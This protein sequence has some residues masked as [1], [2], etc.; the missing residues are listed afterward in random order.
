MIQGFQKRQRQYRNTKT[1]HHGYVTTERERE[2][3]NLTKYLRLK[4]NEHSGPCHK[5]LCN[6]CDLKNTEATSQ[7]RAR[8]RLTSILTIRERHLAPRLRLSDPVYESNEL[9][10]R[11]VPIDL[12]PRTTTKWKLAWARSENAAPRDEAAFLVPHWCSQGECPSILRTALS[13]AR[14]RRRQ[15]GVETARNQDAL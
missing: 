8:R 3:A 14:S 15:K 4:R 6:V 2:R 9:V 11:G 5:T 1:T 7:P 13:L 12:D 10:A